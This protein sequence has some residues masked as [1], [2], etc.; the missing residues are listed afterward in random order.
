SGEEDVMRDDLRVAGLI[1][2]RS[3][4]IDE[5]IS[6]TDFTT[7]GNDAIVDWVW[8]ELRDATNNT[9]VLSSQSALLQRDGDV[10]SINGTSPLAFT[11]APGNYYVAIA[12]RNHLG[13][14]TAN[15]VTL[16][17]TV[18]S[19]DLT[20]NS[21]LIYQGTAAMVTLNNDKLALI[22]GD[23]NTSGQVQN[24]DLDIVIGLNGEGGSYFDADIDS[25]SQ[26]QNTDI[27]II[28]TNNGK[29]E[30]INLKTDNTKLELV[31]IAPLNITHKKM[32]NK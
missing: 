4:Y 12:H 5:L 6:D 25:N 24:E 16:N 8:V 17:Q 13:I 22:A 18:S 15:T 2:L 23:A 26:V 11:L 31:I 10:V 28:T 27:D 9:T 19:L 21:S 7:V 3:P 29:G 32:N 1:P 20:A 14:I 30:Q